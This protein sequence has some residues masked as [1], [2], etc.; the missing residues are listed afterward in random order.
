MPT[1]ASV[2]ILCLLGLPASP[3]PPRLRI[4]IV[5]AGIP[6][7]PRFEA[8]V[9]EEV[10]HIWSA[11]GV[12]IQRVNPDDEGRDDAVRLTVVL[13]DRRQP[14]VPVEALGSILFLDDSPEP[15]VAMY[16]NAVAALVAGAKLSDHPD[17]D[18]PT[19]LRD[20]VHGR[21]LGRALA[22]EVGHYLLRTRR[23]SEVGL[24]RTKQSVYDLAGAGR[25]SF[26]LSA[27]QR[28]RLL[29]VTAIS[30]DKTP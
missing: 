6:M 11:Y 13:T 17:T 22:H 21:V 2:L 25:Q 14:Q 24:M 12:D 30:S 7:P 4:D 29:A 18:W 15:V 26:T 3:P 23:H 5:F 19:A 20:F 16:P 9:M 1:I 10:T 8:A 28:A 27:D